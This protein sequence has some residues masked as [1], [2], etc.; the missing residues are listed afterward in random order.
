MVLGMAT[1]G[2]GALLTAC[3][4]PK[5]AGGDKKAAEKPAEKPAEPAEPVCDDQAGVDDKMKTT[6]T[7]FKYVTE[8][9]NPAKRCDN[10]QL[11]KEGS[12]CG[13]CTVVKGPIA[14]AGYCTAWAPKA[15]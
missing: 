1:A 14:P 9:P 7:T 2:A 12:P 11:Y 5:R 4:S 13:T 10:C 15:G 3:G 8:T 6:R